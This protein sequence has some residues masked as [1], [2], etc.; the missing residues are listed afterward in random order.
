M[1]K[2]VSVTMCAPRRQLFRVTASGSS[3]EIDIG[4][5]VKI[6]LTRIVTLGVLSN[7]IGIIGTK[8]ITRIVQTTIYNIPN[9]PALGCEVGKYTV[10]P[11]SETTFTTLTSKLNGQHYRIHVYVVDQDTGRAAE[12]NIVIYQNDNTATSGVCHWDKYF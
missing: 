7:R 6:A 3:A 4:L 1:C 2:Y 10:S 5:D 11:T 9:V 12:A 8:E